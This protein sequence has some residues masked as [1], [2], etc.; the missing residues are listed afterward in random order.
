MSETGGKI[1]M[2]L[3][4][5]LGNPTAKYEKTRHN[6][7]FDVGFVR[8]WAVNHGQQIENT[9]IDTVELGKTLIPDLNN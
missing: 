4:V 9:I 6:A 7:G 1:E 2:Y 5:G 3:I 8:Q